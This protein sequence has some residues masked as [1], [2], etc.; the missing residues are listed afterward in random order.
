MKD[1]LF[2][3]LKDLSEYALSQE[4]DDEEFLQKVESAKSVVEN[5]YGEIDKLKDKIIEQNDTIQKLKQAKVAEIF[6]SPGNSDSKLPE[7]E[8][9]MEEQI[10][11]LF[12]EGVNL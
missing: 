10:P 4:R 11:Q 2:E 5:H 3:S 1:E 8:P 12:K 9:V 6:S 7:E